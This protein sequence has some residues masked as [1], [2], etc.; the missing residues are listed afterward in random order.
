MY[1]KTTKNQNWMCSHY[2]WKPWLS[3]QMHS[4]NKTMVLYSFCLLD[5]HDACVEV[6]Q[7]NEVFQ[8]IQWKRHLE[9]LLEDKT[10]NTVR[11]WSVCWKVNS[12]SWLYREYFRKVV[13]QICALMFHVKICYSWSW[14]QFSQCHRQCTALLRAAKVL[15]STVVFAF[16]VFNYQYAPWFRTQRFL[17]FIPV[18]ANRLMSVW[19]RKFPLEKMCFKNVRVILM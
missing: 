13:Q 17:W 7:M 5:H 8:Q 9:H 12:C 19:P 16:C 3:F 10:E 1:L 14:W 15:N 4:V 2:G 18:V 6:L 11:S